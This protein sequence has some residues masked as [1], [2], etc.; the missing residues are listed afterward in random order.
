M[1]TWGRSAVI[2]VALLAV[3]GSTVA[4][5]TIESVEKAIIE[6]GK[7]IESLQFKS[8]TSSDFDQPGWKYKQEMDGTY[9]YALDAGKMLYRIESK[10]ITV[11]AQEGNEETRKSNTLMVCDGAFIWISSE[12]DGQKTVMK[13]KASN[14]NWFVSKAYFNN[15]RMMYNLKLLPDETVDGRSTWAIEAS[16]KPEMASGPSATTMTMYHDKET[17]VGYKTI[18]KNTEGKVVS[19]STTSDL[20]VNSSIDRDLFTFKV[21]EGVEVMDLTQQ[22]EQPQ[23][24]AEEPAKKQEAKKAEPKKPKEEK[25]KEEPKKEKKKKGKLPELPKWP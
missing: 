2:C 6:Q 10:D 14:Q 12:T 3:V 24:A 7:K 4:G 5:D 20:K 25:K 15:M 18:S 9:H 22:Q 1:T 23:P 8:K 16:P 21:P 19:T 13:Q 11:T 17:G